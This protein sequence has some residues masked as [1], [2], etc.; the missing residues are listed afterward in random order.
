[1]A[2]AAVCLVLGGLLAVQVHTQMAR[3]AS[4]VG[5]Q[6]SAL[7]EML[8]T[9]QA[10][11]EGQKKEI[12]RL[13]AR[14]AKY[15]KEAASEKGLM[16][17]MSE[18]LRST[19]I[20]LGLFPVRGPGIELELGDS[21]MRAGTQIG[22]QGSF[23]IHDFD[24]VQ[25]ANEL[26]AA[27]A[28]AVS[29]NGQRLAA[30]SAITCSGKLIEVNG[31]TISTPFTFLAIGDRDKLMSALNIRGGVLDGMRLLQFHV[32]LTPKEQLIIPPIGVAPKYEFA[33][34]VMKE[35]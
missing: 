30:G 6:T 24:L 5:R 23:V 13:R 17:L 8:T 4:K 35:E 22:D 18:E 15:E 9:T 1:M 34:P 25:V 32:K 26:W 28:E 27:G 19:R 11:V 7:V 12:E 29:L 33:Q 14:V 3:G 31:A 16:R 20:T 21:T 2:I 10:Q